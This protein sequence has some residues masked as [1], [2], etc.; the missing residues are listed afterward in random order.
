M[1]RIKIL[2]DAYEIKPL[3][4]IYLPELLKLQE[5]AF[6]NLENEELLRRNSDTTLRDCLVNHYTLGVIYKG[7]LIAFG[8][9]YFGKLTNEN[10]GYDLDLNIDEIIKTANIKLIIVHSAYRGNGLQRRL[11]G[12]LEKEAIKRGF[13]TLACTIA[14]GNFYSIRNFEACG[15]KFYK[16]KQKYNGLIRNIYLK[17]I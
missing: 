1:S 15:F 12:E 11:I 10:I 17:K 3:S 4:D 5:N 6:L 14:P 7:I 9:L 8:I 2:P 13:N 16:Q